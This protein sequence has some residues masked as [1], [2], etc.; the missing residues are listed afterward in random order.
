MEEVEPQACALFWL[1]CSEGSNPCPDGSSLHTSPV[2]VEQKAEEGQ[3]RRR[4][5]WQDRLASPRRR[6]CA[7]MKS[8]GNS[9]GRKKRTGAGKGFRQDIA[10]LAD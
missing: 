2:Q 3:S 10:G 1:P 5:A 6:R 4:R 8:S 7:A 9:E